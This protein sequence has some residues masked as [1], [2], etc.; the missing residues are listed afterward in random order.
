MNLYQF[1]KINLN[2]NKTLHIRYKIPFV[3]TKD[4]TTPIQELVKV[5][6]LLSNRK[7]RQ[8]ILAFVLIALPSL[9]VT[10]SYIIS[11]SP[12]PK[13]GME[14]N[15]YP[16][17]PLSEGLLF[18]VIDGGRRDMMSNPEF[19]PHLNSRVEE[20]AYLE[21]QTNPMTMTAICVKELATGVPSRPN[22]ALQNFHPTHPGTPDGWNLASTHDADGDGEYDHQVGILGD[23]VWKD[24]YPDRE[25]IPFS[26]HRYGHADFYQGDEEAFVTLN[27]WLGGT[28]PSGAEKAP[29]IIIAHIS[30]LD[31]VGHRY[32]AKDSPEYEEKLRWLDD[33]LEI[34][35]QLVPDNWTV[36]VTSDHGLT[37]TGQHGSPEDIVRE[38]AAFMWGPN[39]AHGVTVEG[40]AQRDLATL[41]SILFS[42]PFPHAIHGRIPLEAFSLSEEQHTTYE[43]WNWDAAIERNNWMEE[44]G[45][46]HID[47][48]SKDKIEWD[49]LQGDEIGM[50]N[51][52]LIITVLA[53]LVFS[54]LLY[55][56]IN[57][58]VI[59]SKT[60]YKAIGLFTAL[61]ALSAF[62][63]YSRDWLATIYYPLGL[64]GLLTVFAMNEKSL[65]KKVDD[66]ID[67]RNLWIILAAFIFAVIYPETRF[68][69]IM[70]PI[71][72]SLLLRK[73]TYRDF[74][75]GPDSTS[76]VLLYPLMLILI[77]AIFFSDYR[78]YGLAVPRFMVMF[79][80]SYETDALIWSVVIAFVFTLIYATRNRD[81]PLVVAIATAATMATIPVM[82]SQN[83]D[84]VDWI[85]IYGL[86]SGLAISICLKILGHKHSFTVFQYCAF[87][88][89]TMSWGAWGGGVS[90][91]FFG[92][93]ESL[94]N[95]EWSFLKDK[96]DN[97]QAEIVRHIM[98]GLIPIGI[99]FAWWASLGQTDGILHPRDI[100]PGNL[101]LKGGY[102]GDR[103]SPSNTWVGFMGAGPV[104][105]VGILWW[106]LFR[107]VGWPLQ[108]AFAILIVRISALAMQLS[109]SPNLPRLVFKISWDMIFCLMIVTVVGLY[110]LHEKWL[111]RDF[112]TETSEV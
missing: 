3:R 68:T 94:M 1:D 73:Q 60:A 80:Q 44:E 65:K 50:R 81:L 93:V 9:F 34:A 87:A 70:A 37:D 56:I 67:L 86:L 4:K 59:Q 53:V 46:S 90:M 100:D 12:A 103:L 75:G 57:P 97:L 23:Y 47:G 49:E 11:D 77:T 101:F 51:L 110:I 29:N 36:V 35:F 84:Y 105:L 58:T 89:A 24:L 26:Q 10:G 39:I 17:D 83:S 6:V 91:I 20:G 40:V 8:A 95:K 13:E 72:A 82:I 2:N 28:V 27:S 62:I 104:V 69:I 43:Q 109:V 5:L 16:E 79:T 15:P 63:S 22:E 98:L 66:E 45:H 106:N 88:W 111:N 30:G 25:L 41:P 112:N 54:V 32:D 42:L 64:F 7:F 48:L 31:S 108:M 33:N 19:M 85:L 14:E 74:L 52:D 71:L 18:V 92:C 96:N 107:K 76:K 21:I 78:V 61:F 102:I 38:T 99:W 55:R